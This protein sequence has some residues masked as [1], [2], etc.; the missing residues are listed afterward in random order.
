M[1]NQDSTE[2]FRNMPVPKA[3]MKN[4]LPAMAAMLMVLIYN[5]A[6]T[7]FIGQTHDDL[8]VAAV[9][10]ATPVFLIFMAVGTVFGIGGTSV[11]SRAMGQGRQDHAK[12]VCSFCMWGCVAVGAAMSAFFLLFMDEIL[13]WIGATPDTW[14]YAKTYLTIVSCCGPFVLIGNCYSN[15]IRAE[16][17]SGKAMMGQLIGNLLN[18]VLD[19]LL[20]LVFGW[21]IAGAAVATVIGNVVGA[22]YYILYFLRGS[23]TLSIR[24]KDF[25]LG[26]GVCSGVL[27]IGI[28][29]SLGSLLMSVSQ[30][31]VNALMTDYGDMALAGI[32]VAMK[33]SMMTGMVCIG[34]GQGIQPLLGYCVGAKLWE[35]FKKVMKF[36]LVFSLA[37]SVVMTGVCYLFTNGI[38]SAFLTDPAAFDYA[39]QFSRILLTTSFLFGAFYVLSNALQAM[40]AATAALIVNLSRQGIIYIPAL[41][42]LKAALGAAG[43]AWA[44]PVADL[45]S[46]ALVAVLYLYTRK[47]AEKSADIGGT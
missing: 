46:T 18:V 43:L 25:A 23:S 35:R 14:D 19:P 30:I 37:L 44:Q 33:V 7:F 38:V 39:V 47:R 32:G 2:L 41:F 4:A 20:I 12:K 15:V 1:K 10:L 22:G 9:S 5:L 42:I 36:S 40:G 24:L 45:L 27:A 17:Q 28:P 21:D 11:I 3:V 13:G 8:Q 26:G 16:G 31:I 34:F 29:A 6:D